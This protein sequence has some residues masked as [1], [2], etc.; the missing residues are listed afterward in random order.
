VAWLL[1]GPKLSNVYIALVK[2]LLAQWV[3]VLV[4]LILL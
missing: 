4:Q 3:D 1:D 2:Y